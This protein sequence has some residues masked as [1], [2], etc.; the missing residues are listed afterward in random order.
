MYGTVNLG[1]AQASD[2]LI[3]VEAIESESGFTF[4][5]SLDMIW[6]RFRVDVSYTTNPGF[7]GAVLG[8]ADGEYEVAHLC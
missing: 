3:L 5:G 4:E 2:I 6:E 1:A 8:I 7:D